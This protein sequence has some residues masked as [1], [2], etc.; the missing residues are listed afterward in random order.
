MTTHGVRGGRVMKIIWMW[1]FIAVVFTVGALRFVFQGNLPKDP[2]PVRVMNPTEFKNNLQIGA[3][4]YRRFWQE[5]HSENLVIVGSSPF[6]RGYDEVW[7]GLL[8][9]MYEKKQRFDVIFEQEGLRS[10]SLQAQPLDWQKV[11]AA[12]T[13]GQKIF[14]HLVATDQMWLEAKKHAPQGL[15]L[16]QAVLPITANETG[17]LQIN[18]N[19][20]SKAL[21]PAQKL[22]CLSIDVQKRSKRRDRDLVPSKTWGIVEQV[23]MREHVIYVHEKQQ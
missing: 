13:S 5:F 21:L 6:L 18:C 3:V 9:T 12:V 23:A 14:V 4:V 16:M 7:R 10:L 20:S 22:S 11:S 8:A 2:A 17:F 15:Y 1:V 19:H